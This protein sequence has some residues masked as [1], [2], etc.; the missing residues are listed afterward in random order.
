MKRA[1]NWG[2]VC[3][4]ISELKRGE[5]TGKTGSHKCLRETIIT[6]GFSSLRCLVHFWELGMAASGGNDAKVNASKYHKHRGK[7][8]LYSHVQ[9]AL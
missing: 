3:C 6:R 5:N 2:I 8:L 9:Q 1:I 7:Q 4:Y